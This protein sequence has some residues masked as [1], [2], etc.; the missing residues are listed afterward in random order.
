MKGDRNQETIQ[1]KRALINA[2]FD[3]NNLRVKHGT[4]TAWGWL[5]V[6]ADMHRAPSCCCGEPDMYGRRE[7]CEPCKDLWRTI[8]SRMVEVTMQTTGRQGDYDG[9]I[10]IDLGIID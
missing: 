2:G 5:K 6:Y 1:V 10:L 8:H 9:R 7:T 4:G 3:A